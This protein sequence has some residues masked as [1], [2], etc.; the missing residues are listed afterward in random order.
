MID[1]GWRRGEHGSQ[2]S[3]SAW[4]MVSALQQETGNTKERLAQK[5]A[6]DA[7]GNLIVARGRRGFA[8]DFPERAAGKRI[9]HRR[10]IAEAVR[11]RDPV[12]HRP[13]IGMQKLI[14]LEWIVVDHPGAA[15]I[16][17]DRAR[18]HPVVGGIDEEPSSRDSWPRPSRRSRLPEECSFCGWSC[19]LRTRR[20]VRMRAP[21]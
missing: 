14:D 7:A 10:P 13:L 6:R 9:G 15:K 11:P 20:A 2:Y 12:I 1:A 19:L 21:R 8:G 5:R 18:R 3:P 17:A 4:S 16:A